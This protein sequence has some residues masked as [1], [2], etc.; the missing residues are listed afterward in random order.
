MYNLILFAVQISRILVY[1]SRLIVWMVRL[2][3]SFCLSVTNFLS[4]SLFLTSGTIVS[5]LA[6]HTYI[7][8]GLQRAMLLACARPVVNCCAGVSAAVGAPGP[9]GGG[10]S[11]FGSG[12][13]DVAW[14]SGESDEARRPVKKA[15]LRAWSFE[16]WYRWRPSRGAWSFEATALSSVPSWASA[17]KRFLLMLELMCSLDWVLALRII[18]LGT[19]QSL[20]CV[21][22]SAGSCVED[23]LL[24]ERDS[25][26]FLAKFGATP[27]FALRATSMAMSKYFSND[28]EFGRLF[29]FLERAD[30]RPL[31]SRLLVEG[32]G[33]VIAESALRRPCFNFG[34][35]S[36]GSS[37][38]AVISSAVAFGIGFPS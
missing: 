27:G 26:L 30:L 20:C 21:G 1:V 12:A 22:L 32:D 11:G 4:M 8:G 3:G 33:V 14:L 25:G 31:A 16:V 38:E 5:R 19:V 36:L 15:S 13:P 23:R 35:S 29:S 34:D 17:S 37:G 18:F 28:D 6:L 24:S 7:G 9:S 2:L 10:P